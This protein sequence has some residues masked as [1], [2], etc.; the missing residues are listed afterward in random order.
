L[1]R[2]NKAI[3]LLEQGQP[4]YWRR[5]DDPAEQTYAGGVKLA[6]TWAD[7]LDY[8]MELAPYDIYRLRDFMRG[9]VDGG[10]TKSGHR[11][12]A[13]IV[14][15]PL[16][17][18]NQPMVLANGWIIRQLLNTGV[19]GL[20]LCHAETPEAVKA[21][22]E[23]CRFAFHRPG[24]GQGLDEG[25]RGH[26]DEQT[27]AGVWGLSVAEYKQR[28]DVWPLNPTGE[29][30]L[31]LKIE[32]KWCA[33]NCERTVKVP[34]ICYAEWGVNDM[35]LS[36]GYTSTPTRPFPPEIEAV[37]ARIVGACQAAGLFFQEGAGPSRIK[38]QIDAG[39]KILSTDGGLEK[40][41]ETAEIGRQYTRRTMPW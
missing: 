10:P 15:M 9:L 16:E 27:P 36:M 12:P 25:R 7:Y 21:F 8:N 40:G 39:I 30:M 6:R 35:A 34:G 37:R 31:G 3:E 29:L 17:G 32:T 13:V 38:Q 28:A 19:H 23:T 22:V 20:H 4:V 2:I 33:E 41:A 18:R 11:T 26:S 14:T 5:V 24:V 1:A